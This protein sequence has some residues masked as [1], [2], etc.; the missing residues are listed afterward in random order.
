MNRTNVATVAAE[1]AGNEHFSGSVSMQSLA[2][3]D[4]PRGSALLVTFQA[5][6]RTYWHSHPDGQFL[7]VTDGEGRTASRGGVI[8]PLRPGDL[9]YAAPNEQHWHGASAD[10]AVSHLALSFGDTQWFEE[11]EP[12]DAASEPAR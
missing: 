8:E 5:G 2:T 3:V 4:A 1:P 11:V 9:V 12:A 6:A 7:Y 10:R